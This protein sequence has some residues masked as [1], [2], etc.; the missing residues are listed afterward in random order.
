M[1]GGRPLPGVGLAVN[2]PKW[3]TPPN[4]AWAANVDADATSSKVVIGSQAASI[5]RWDWAGAISWVVVERSDPSIV[6]EIYAE[7]VQDFY[8]DVEIKIK[9]QMVAAAGPADASDTLGEGIAAFHLK[10]NGKTPDVVL[11][12]PDSFREAGGRQ[13]AQ[14]ERRRRDPV[15]DRDAQDDLGGLARR[16]FGRPARGLAVSGDPSRHRRPHDRARPFDRQRH[17][18][19]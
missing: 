15:R 7:A 2:K 18:R 5:L 9:D 13:P 1:F 4:G 12:A 10:S 3:T 6:D 14:L 8:N 17:R 19:S 16:G 11:M